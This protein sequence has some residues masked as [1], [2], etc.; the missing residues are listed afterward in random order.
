MR[1]E[2]WCN[3]AFADWLRGTMKPGAE[4]ISGWETW[5][6][7]AKKAHPIRYW[8][9]EEGLDHIQKF[10]WWPIDRLYDVKYYINNRWVTRT[11]ALTAHPRTSSQVSGRMLAVVFFLA[12]LTSLWILLKLNKRGIMLYGTTKLKRN[13]MHLGGQKD[14]S[15]GALGV[16]RKLDLLTWIGRLN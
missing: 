9:A 11:H 10:L 5:R 12:C 14:G 8:L 2:Y 6:Q 16:A 3:S 15:A 13:M 4:T 1:S 7:Q